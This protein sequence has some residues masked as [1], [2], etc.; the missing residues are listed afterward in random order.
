MLHDDLLVA[1]GE[2]ERVLAHHG[3]GGWKVTVIVRNPS[4]K[5]GEWI[6]ETEDDLLAVSTLIAQHFDDAPTLPKEEMRR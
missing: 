6:M 4:G 3:I 2:I 1:I 5:P